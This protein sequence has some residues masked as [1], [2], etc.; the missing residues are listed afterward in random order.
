[1]RNKDLSLPQNPTLKDF[2]DYVRKLEKI[3][4]F[5]KENILEKCLMLGEEVGEIFKSVRKHVGIKIDANSEV[6]DISDEIADVFIFLLSIAN[7]YDINIE[8]AF[9]R[10]EE[11]NKKRIW[12]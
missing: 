3:R 11:K 12:S 9:R 5:E 7:R 2:H 8:D 4:G 6:L 1:M 10:K